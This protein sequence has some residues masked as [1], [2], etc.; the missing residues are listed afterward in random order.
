M[1]DGSESASSVS[2]LRKEFTNPS[3]QINSAL[4]FALKRIRESLR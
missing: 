1:D 2:N 3:S 4:I